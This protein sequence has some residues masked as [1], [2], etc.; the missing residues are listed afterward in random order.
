MPHDQDFVNLVAE[1]RPQIKELATSE[2]KKMLATGSPFTF[3]DVREDH[4]WNKGH[5]P[6]AVHIGRGI[7]ERDIANLVAD[8][9]QK[10]VLYCGGGFRSILSAYNLHK[11]GYTNVW[12]MDG[13]YREWCD[14]NWE[15]IA[16]VI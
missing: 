16:T 5:L 10:I 15:I 11:M 13:G 8:K 4:E 14:N 7:L 1:L 6:T 12:S 3:I 9:Q 2:V